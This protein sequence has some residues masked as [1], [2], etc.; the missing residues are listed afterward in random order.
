MEFFFPATFWTG[1]SLFGLP[2]SPPHEP[3]FHTFPCAPLSAERHA[4]QRNKYPPPPSGGVTFSPSGVSSWRSGLFF[5]IGPNLPPPEGNVR[6]DVSGHERR[7]VSSRRHG[8]RQRNTLFSPLPWT[9]QIFLWLFFLPSFPVYADRC[10]PSPLGKLKR[11]LSAW[12]ESALANPLP[13]LTN[14]LRHL[15]FFFSTPSPRRREPINLKKSP[16]FPCV[17]RHI[18][19]RM[20]LRADPFSAVF[21][22]SPLPKQVPRNAADRTPRPLTKHHSSSP[23][24]C[25]NLTFFPTKR[26][27]PHSSLFSVRTVTT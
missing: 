27:S 10:Q 22:L 2:P 9:V 6:G 14:S 3:T 24:S 13:F 17:R 4:K 16:F 11:H 1:K 21:F 18:L 20:V 8:F 23:H 25:P 15:P 26:G 19:P 7:S 5:S 12:K